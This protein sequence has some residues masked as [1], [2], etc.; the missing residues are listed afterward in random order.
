MKRIKEASWR[1][2][3]QAISEDKENQEDVPENQEDS[4][5]NEL[6]ETSFQALY[7]TLK[8]PGKIPKNQSENLSVRSSA[9]T[10]QLNNRRLIGCLKLAT[11]SAR[12]GTRSVLGSAGKV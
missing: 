3:T 9:G 7:K 5:A 11:C 4:D 1:I 10:L 8:M 12:L 2:L 6:P